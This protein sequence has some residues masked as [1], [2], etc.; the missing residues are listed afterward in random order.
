MT[1]A[2]KAKTPMPM[3]TMVKMPAPED[4]KP[5]AIKKHTTAKKRVKASPKTGLPGVRGPVRLFTM[6]PASAMPHSRSS[7]SISF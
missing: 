7:C 3:G 4:A 1:P 6:R 5:D 2:I